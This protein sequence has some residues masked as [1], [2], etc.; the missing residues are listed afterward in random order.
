MKLVSIIMTC[1]NGEKYLERAVSSII[2]QT[3]KN[4]EIIF[5]DNNSIDKSKNIITMQ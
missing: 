2:N 4:W 5:I 1:L 3:Y